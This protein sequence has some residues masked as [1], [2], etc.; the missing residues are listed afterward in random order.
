LAD[1]GEIEVRFPWRSDIRLTDD[2]NEGNSAAVKV[3]ESIDVDVV[4]RL[5]G[6][7]FHMDAG[8]PDVPS[9][10]VL[11]FDFQI[12]IC[13]DRIFV[14]RNLVALREIRI[15]VVLAG[16]N[17]TGSDGTMGGKTHSYD[18]IDKVEIEYREDAGHSEANR[19]D[20]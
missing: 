12:P 3:D 7:L 13:A 1:L 9:G 17:G 5:S 20:V 15:E 11:Q 10:P 4:D 14:L 18:I 6:I 16:K 2:F 8:D 19:A